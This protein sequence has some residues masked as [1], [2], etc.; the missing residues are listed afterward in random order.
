MP[1]TFAK[2][3]FTFI[4]EHEKNKRSTHLCHTHVLHHSYHSIVRYNWA[5][6]KCRFNTCLFCLQFNIKERSTYWE[7]QSASFGFQNICFFWFFCFF[8]LNTTIELMRLFAASV[9]NLLL[10]TSAQTNKH[11]LKPERKIL[12]NSLF[13]KLKIAA[14]EFICCFLHAERIAHWCQICEQIKQWRRRYEF[15]CSSSNET[16][17]AKKQQKKTLL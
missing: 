2:S 8:T 7:H 6:K 11:Q 14:N 9:L 12:N 13:Y 16:G 1:L 4:L 3:V 15:I 17:Q 5:R 10:I